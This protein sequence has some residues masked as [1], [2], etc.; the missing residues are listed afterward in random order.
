MAVAIIAVCARSAE[1]KVL[2]SDRLELRWRSREE[3][4]AHVKKWPGLN[5][6]PQVVSSPVWA[7]LERR[8]RIL[9]A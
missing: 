7:R 4:I 1:T 5:H 9:D 8:E 2:E 3:A 6:S